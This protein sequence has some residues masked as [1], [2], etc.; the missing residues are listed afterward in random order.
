MK[1]QKFKLPPLKVEHVFN[2][3]S[4]T[5]DWGIQNLNIPKLWKSTEGENVIIGVIDTGWPDHPDIGDNAIKGKSFIKNESIEDK[6]GHQ[7][8]CVGIISAKNNEIG[9]VGVAP[10]AKCLCVKGLS[11]S[12]SGSSKGIAEAID[13]CINEGVDLISMSLGASQ[14]SSE[15][16]SSVRKA[17]LKNIP[18]ICA[19]GNSG[20]F[21]VNYPAAFE[22][23]IA[24]AA[25][26]KNNQIASF[27]SRG[28]QVEIA[29]PGVQVFSTYKNKTYAK[30]SGTSMACPFV[31][32]VVALLIS[33][34]KKNNEKYTVDEIRNLLKTTADDMG[35][36]G[37]DFDWGYGIIDADGIILNTPDP[38]PEPEPEPEPKPEPEPE[39]EPEP[40][41][42]PEPEPEPEPEPKPEPEPEPEPEPKPEPEPE[43]EPE[44]KP[45]KKWF[46]K[47]IAWIILGSFLIIALSIFLISKINSEPKPEYIKEDGSVD[48]DLKFLL[49]K[50]KKDG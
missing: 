17:Y 34:K 13:Y 25:F 2:T 3:L 43:P 31:A 22:E 26:S 1:E 37:R 40:K 36:V 39:P 48:W 33:Q 29:A 21:G 19:A 35:Q 20:I 11:N 23:C 15:I 45:E 42:K 8:H 28:K 7:T 24:V 5:Q 14:P 30:L 12:G 27:S 41:P 38:E 32:G 6:H 4:Q 46:I 10:K 50:N 16:Q 18:V 9:S 44:P 47:N 49:E